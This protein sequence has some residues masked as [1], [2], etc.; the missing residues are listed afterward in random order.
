MRRALVAAGFLIV[1]ASMVT[2]GGRGNVVRHYYDDGTF[3]EIL[4]SQ[5]SCRHHLS[6]HPLDTLATTNGYVQGLGPSACN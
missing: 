4:A 1:L 5:G 6:A 3:K 2:A